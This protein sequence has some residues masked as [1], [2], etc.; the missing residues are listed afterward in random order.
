MKLL[1]S[2]ILPLVIAASSFIS[3]NPLAPAA[4]AQEGKAAFGDNVQLRGIYANSRHIFERTGKGRVAFI[5][6][7]ITEMD[8]YRPM[9][10]E[11]LKKRFPKTEFEFIAAGISSTCSTTG[12]FRL[13]NDVLSKGPIDLFF[14]EF[15]V[16]DDQD[17]HHSRENAIRGLEGILQHARKSNPAMDIVVTFFVNEGMIQTYNKGDIPLSVEA[18]ESV[19]KHH[20][21]STI[22]LGKEVAAQI[23]DGHL[24][25]K[26]FG[27]VHPAPFGNAICARMIDDLLNRTW[28]GPVADAVKPHPTQP[29][30]DPLSYRNGRFVA[31]A[32]AVVK[33]GWTL[34]VP[35]W[36]SLPGGKRQRFN[37]LDLLSATTPGAEL[38]LDFEGTAIGA[39]VL[40]G[41]DAGT[42]EATIDDA[43][44]VTV[45]VFH[46]YSKGLHYPRTV[47]FGNDLKPGKHRLVL[48]VTPATTSTGNA[49]RIMQFT[50]N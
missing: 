9:V 39:F 18:H 14:V 44:P 7:S 25:W 43:K 29:N 45:D 41:P 31:P 38:T 48:K 36:K 49:V 27:G 6:G 23:R 37:T 47:M 3:A 1:I 40:A 8:G 16:N 33:Q 5:G 42:V 30:L 21:I 10:C 17:A 35:D 32:K 13:E 28:T 50:A 12:A 22:H 19:A 46:A 11:S 2:R 15:A 4:R 34:G 26:Q 24:T 20:N